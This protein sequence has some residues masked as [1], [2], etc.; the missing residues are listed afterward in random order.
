MWRKTP[1]PSVPDG[2]RVYAIGD[3]HGRLDLL[4]QLLEMIDQ[5]AAGAPGKQVI[6][7]FL[8]DYIDRGSA[9]AGVIERLIEIR[10]RDPG[11]VFLRGN[12]EQVLLEFLDSPERYESWRAFGADETLISY[13][14]APPAFEDLR[15][16]EET[17]NALRLELPPEHL[18]FVNATAYSKVI[19]DY[20]FVHAGIRPG[21][22]LGEQRPHD[23]M[24]IRDEFLNS[25][26]KF[27]KIVVH[28]H[29]PRDKPDI[30]PNR[31]GVDTKAYKSGRLTA[32]AL[33]GTQKRFLT[34]QK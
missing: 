14:V 7:I 16:Y 17:R 24:W 10:Q 13:N 2:L 19:G 33:E 6:R 12:H 8:G 28:G 22:F 31:I 26:A 18:A 34:A 3:I 27:E 21:V 11:A 1:Q 25:P 30:R 9:S 32:L 4:E 29:T 5:E 20:L 23:M 15:A